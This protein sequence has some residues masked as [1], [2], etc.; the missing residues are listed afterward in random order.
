[1]KSLSNIELKEINAGNCI[2]SPD[3]AVTRFSSIGCLIGRAIGN[4]L[5]WLNP[6]K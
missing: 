5:S 3:P 6:F 4:T 2:E 1:M